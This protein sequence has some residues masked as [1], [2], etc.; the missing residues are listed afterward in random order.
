MSQLMYRENLLDH[1]KNPR[2]FGGLTGCDLSNREDNPL[3]GDEIGIHVKFKDDTLFEIMFEG[4]GCAISQ[5]SASM[6]TEFVKGKSLEDV[7]KFSRE[8][9][10]SLL[11]VEVT[12]MRLKCALL[13]WNVLQNLLNKLEDKK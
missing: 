5:A 7:R 2:N 4:H 9:M 12:P 3:C 13:A 11:M 10:L 8:D 1:Y 6:L